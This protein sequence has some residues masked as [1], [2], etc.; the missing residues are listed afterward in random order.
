M[1]EGQTRKLKGRQA[2]RDCCLVDL[3]ST[4]GAGR[5]WSAWA[6]A[7]SAPAA[8]GPATTF[9][10]A[11][12]VDGVLYAGSAKD[13]I[14]EAADVIQALWNEDRMTIRIPHVFVT[15]GTGYS[16]AGKVQ[17]TAALPA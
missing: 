13:P 9:G 14:P 12:D 2:S 6:V 1:S 16:E 5:L 10:V 7:M 15:N 3:L 11:F 17:S 8:S 4:A